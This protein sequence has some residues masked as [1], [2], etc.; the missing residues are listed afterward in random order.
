MKAEDI[1]SAVDGVDVTEMETSEVVDL[2]QES[3]KEAVTL[4]VHRQDVEEPLSFPWKS[5]M[6]SFHGLS[7]DAGRKYRLYPYQQLQRSDLRAVSG[8]VRAAF[9]GRNGATDHR[10]AGKSGRPS[11]FSL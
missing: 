9:R 8:S 3:S 7:G 1:I 10:P 5:Q 11:D 4:T 6:W 2:V